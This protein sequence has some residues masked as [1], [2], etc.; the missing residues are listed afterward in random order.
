LKPIEV[1]AGVRPVLQQPIQDVDRLPHAARDEVAEQRYVSGVPALNL[2]RVREPSL[3]HYVRARK[4][5]AA[6]IDWTDLSF[7]LSR[8]HRPLRFAVLR[9][10]IQFRKRLTIYDSRNPCLALKKKGIGAHKKGCARNQ[11]LRGE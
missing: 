11:S 3:R 10:D 8:Y 7:Q 1:P 5:T 9:L 6:G 4:L 2:H